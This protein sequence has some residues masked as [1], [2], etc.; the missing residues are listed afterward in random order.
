MYK[1]YV[2]PILEFACPIVNPY[3]AKDIKAI[4]K[5]QRDFV[6][7][8]YRRSPKSYNKAPKDNSIPHQSESVR[9]ID[10]LTQYGLELL[11]KR[12]LKICLTM[13]HNNLHGRLPLEPTQAFQILPS[14]TRGD[15]NKIVTKPCTKD[16]RHNSFFVRIS[17]IYSQL[18]HE[19]RNCH[20]I[21]FYSFL[22]QIDLNPYL[23]ITDYNDIFLHSLLHI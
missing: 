12:R 16:V 14:I 6:K 7:L 21:Q 23:S 13:F 19:I 4:E 1:A 15:S 10:L 2:L 8:V 18:P 20:P 11:E 3:Y 17:T 9:Y 22:N 5:V